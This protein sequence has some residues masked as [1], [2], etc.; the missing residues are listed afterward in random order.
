MNAEDFNFFDKKPEGISFSDISNLKP[1]TRFSGRPKREM[2]IDQN[3]I[4][5]IRIALGRT[6][7][8]LDFI[9]VIG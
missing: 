7:D 2:V 9:E 1:I 5:D 6:N 8:V 3:D 4:I